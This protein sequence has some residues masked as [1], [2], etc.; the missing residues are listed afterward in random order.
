MQGWSIMD[1]RREHNKTAAGRPFE[2]DMFRP[3][4]AEGIVR[5]FR[6]VYG[7]GY[8]IKIFYDPK[9]LTDANE[10]G[11]YYSIVA[12]N[13][14][15]LCHRS[16]PSLP[17]GSLQVFIRMGGGFGSRRLSRERCFRRDRAACGQSS[18]T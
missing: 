4:D 3:E 9:A 8:P 1:N 5:I 18:D 7:D 2:V 15:G 10:N 11:D 14:D 13:P 17:V 16:S 12:R 6:S